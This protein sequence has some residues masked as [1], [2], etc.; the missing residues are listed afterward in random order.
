MTFTFPRAKR[1]KLF[2]EPNYPK[3]DPRRLILFLDRIAAVT[4][5]ILMVLTPLRGD[6]PLF[7]VGLI[8]YAIGYSIL[9]LS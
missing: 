5:V 4:F 9:I 7:F 6:T 3:G 8:L 2:N 1:K